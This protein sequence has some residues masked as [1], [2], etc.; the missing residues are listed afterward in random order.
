MDIFL[1][2][3]LRLRKRASQKIVTS[4]PVITIGAYSTALYYA[5]VK[6]IRFEEGKPVQEFFRSFRMNFLQGCIGTLLYLI[7]GILLWIV[8][9]SLQGKVFEVILVAYCRYW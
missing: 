1:K 8:L 4:L 6:S 3:V 7:L 5:V 2:K 9:Q